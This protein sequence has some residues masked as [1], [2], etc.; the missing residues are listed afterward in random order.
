MAHAA[1]ESGVRGTVLLPTL[2]PRSRAAAMERAGADVIVK[3]LEELL[4]GVDKVEALS[5]PNKNIGFLKKK[6]A[7]FPLFFQ[8]MKEHNSIFLKQVLHNH[9]NLLIY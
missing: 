8:H 7:F 4:D 9:Q 1:T 2:A 6:I 3:P 5:C